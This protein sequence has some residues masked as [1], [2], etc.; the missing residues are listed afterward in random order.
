MNII[1][2]EWSHGWRITVGIQIL[3]GTVLALGMA[4]SPRSP[5]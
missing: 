3:A 4:A 2:G 5:R 1:V